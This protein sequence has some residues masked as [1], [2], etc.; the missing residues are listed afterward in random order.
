M[1]KK[2][3]KIISNIIRCIFYC[4]IYLN[5]GAIAVFIVAIYG[6]IE[7]ALGYNEDE[8]CNDDNE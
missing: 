3:Y 5:A 6:V 8:M 7:Y 1:N 2:T 4:L